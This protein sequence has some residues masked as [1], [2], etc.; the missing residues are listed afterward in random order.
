MVLLTPESSTGAR[1]TEHRHEGKGRP[2]LETLQGLVGGYLEPVKVRY[3]G[4]VREAYIDE[5]G[6]MKNLRFNEMATQLYH[7]YWRS[8]SQYIRGNMV[9]WVPDPKEKA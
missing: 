8:E 6:R 9:V 3:E 5:D 7:N 1:P 4:R 2:P